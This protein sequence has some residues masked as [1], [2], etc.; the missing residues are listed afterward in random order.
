[1]Y[2][3]YSDR[4]KPHINKVHETRTI[5]ELFSYNNPE[6]VFHDT[7]ESLDQCLD[8]AQ[9]ESNALFSIED[10]IQGRNPGK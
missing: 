8:A 6:P 5:Y 4:Q 3:N 7:F 2:N 10:L 1:M 9:A